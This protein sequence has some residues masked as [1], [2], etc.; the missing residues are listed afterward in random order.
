MPGNIFSRRACKKMVFQGFRCLLH[1]EYLFLNKNNHLI[2]NDIRKMINSYVERVKYA[3]RRS[4]L[5][6]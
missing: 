3:F 2:K 4:C 5:I 6:K 1:F